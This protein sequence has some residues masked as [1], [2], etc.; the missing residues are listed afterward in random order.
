VIGALAAVCIVL[1]LAAQASAVARL[2]RRQGGAD[3]P[4]G[5]GAGG[6]LAHAAGSRGAGYALGD[7][8]PIDGGW[9]VNALRRRRWL[10]RSLSVTS[11]AL[12]LV[13]VGMIGYPFYTNL[14]ADRLQSRLR[15]QF[16]SPELRQDYEQ[17]RQVGLADSSC[18]IEDGDSLT[19]IEI[20]DL[21]I[22]VVVVE[23]VSASALRAGA[24][25]YPSTP[26]PCE[27]GNVGIAGHRTTY[28]R[29]F[30]DLDQLEP[31]DEIILHT[32]VGSCTYRMIEAPARVSPNDV[33]V[34]AS[35]GPGVNRLTLTTCHPPGSA[36]ERLVAVAELVSND[37]TA[38]PAP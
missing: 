19:R 5:A 3:R 10:R 16:S 30:H 25:H 1:V 34:I 32:P 26:L 20:P 13:A 31:N 36:R 6:R 21:Q 2:R 14:Y 22:D 18:Q 4:D 12:A 17:C 15:T 28:G 29:P 24:G 9:L 37:L 38:A 7:D 33:S 23:G 35:A 11:V 8:Q 27:A